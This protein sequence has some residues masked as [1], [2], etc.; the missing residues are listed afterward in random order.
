VTARVEIRP[1]S[2]AD[3]AT[4]VAVLAEHHWFT[5]CLVRQQRG[6]GV[7]LVAWLDGRPAGE[8]FLECERRLRSPRS[9]GS[10]PVC[11]GSAT[12]R[13]SGHS[14]GAASARP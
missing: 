14:G 11:P 6:G 4:L 3:F 9:A 8:V 1:G 10:F 12:W 2:D 5:D 13:S 7:L